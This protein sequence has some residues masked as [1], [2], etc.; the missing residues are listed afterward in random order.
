MHEIM[1]DIVD[2]DKTQLGDRI[3][4][5]ETEADTPHKAVEP[6]D[7]DEYMESNSPLEMDEAEPRRK[8]S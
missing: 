7:N 8:K 2:D 5:H 4:T 3:C 6:D 1:S